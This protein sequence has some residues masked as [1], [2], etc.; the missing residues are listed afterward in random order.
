MKRSEMVE[1]LKIVL[2]LPRLKSLS[3][4]A[5]AEEILTALEAQG[6]APP[7]IETK[8]YDRANCEYHRAH[9]WEEE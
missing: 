8:N 6:M 9:E 2:K 5:L 1:Q 3:E 4:D 7:E